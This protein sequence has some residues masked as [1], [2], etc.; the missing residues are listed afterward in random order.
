MKK[1]SIV[2]LLVL[3]LS[4]SA[5]AMHATG[6]YPPASRATGPYPSL[7]AVVVTVLQAILP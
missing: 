3:S 5:H 7:L 4:V 2:L 1:F 6:P